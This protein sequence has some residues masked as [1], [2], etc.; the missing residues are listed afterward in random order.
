M[1]TFDTFADAPFQIKDE[2][3]TIT[4]A[5]KQGVPA[6]GQGTVTWNIPTDCPQFKDGRTG[7]YCGIVILLS[8]SPLST[9]NIPKDGV[10][11]IADPTADFDLHTGDKI[12]NAL[13]VGAFY[14]GELKGQG[15][16]LTTSLVISNLKPETA[17]YVAGYAVDCQL[18]Y[19][20]EGVR[21]YSDMHN[22][23][24][25]PDTPAVQF[26][27]IGGT[28]SPPLL[29][30]DGTGLIPGMIYQFDVLYGEDY[31]ICK[32]D[33]VYRV[34]INGLNAGTYGDLL[35][36]LN[37]QFALIDNPLQS[38]TSPNAGRLY[39]DPT[40]KKLSQFDG[41]KLVPVSNV[42]V[43]L[44][45]PSV[46]PAN[47]Y[48]HI[49]S[50][51]E[52]Y[53]RTTSP[54]IWSP[55]NVI[56]FGDVNPTNLKCTDFWFD[57]T[58][59]YVW[60]GT[61][62][63]ETN[64]YVDEHDPS[65][66]PEDFCGAYWYDT[67][68][69]PGLYGW[70]DYENTWDPKIAIF[71][72]EPPNDLAQGTYWVDIT[73]DVPTLYQW[74]GSPG[75]FVQLPVVVSN[76]TT[77]PP[78]TVVPTNA[79]WYNPDTEILRQR[80][81][82]TP[83]F[84]EHEVLVWEGNPANVESCELWW[85][86]QTDQLF[87]WDIVNNQWDQ[88]PYFYQQDRDPRLDPIV[89]AGSLWYKPSTKLLTMWD[90]VD[91]IPTDWITHSSDP[92][93]PEE[94]DAWFN[95][96]TKQ[97]NIWQSASLGSW[98]VI[99]P[100]DS[101]NDPT[102]IPNG[103]YWFNT[104][105]NT[106]YTRAGLGWIVTPYTTSSLNA[107]KGDVYFN[108]STNT[109]NTWNGS[110][111]EQS[112]PAIFADMNVR[113]YCA[114]NPMSRQAQMALITAKKGSGMQVKILEPGSNGI[115]GTGYGDRGID[116]I[117]GPHPYS[118]PNEQGYRLTTSDVSEQAFLFGNLMQGATI[119]VQIYGSDGLS[120]YPSYAELGIG[121]DGSPEERRDM[122]DTI[123]HAL[124]YPTVDVELSKQQ[125]SQSINFALE[126]YRK[127]SPGAYKRG[128]FFLD[129]VPRQQKYVLTNKKIGYNKIVNV[130]GAFR[131][132]S[133]FMSSAHGGGVYGQV[134]LQH[135]Y[136][137]GTYD[138]TSFHLVAQYI[139][140]M[141][142]LFATRLTFQWNEANRRLD[143][144]TSFP[145]K[146]RVLL[147][148]TVERTEQELFR[149]RISKTWIR[150]WAIAE[151]KGILG[152]ARS[153]YGSLPGAGGG[154]TLNGS[155]M[156]ASS[157]EEKRELLEEMDNYIASDVEYLGMGSQFVIG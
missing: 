12:S 101:E 55:V 148:T 20:H 21:A 147:D 87:I 75:E 60:N 157:A 56:E 111:W 72:P 69:N 149:D 99:D 23:P 47:T 117:A 38:P 65:C 143:F 30:S 119:P 27:N 84:T 42:L 91:W 105:N 92:S 152:Q 40:N 131:F 64:T 22:G 10:A 4:L 127:R 78:L 6:A 74:S 110:K 28:D 37:K 61:T 73:P 144:Y 121:T 18:R 130:M 43:E 49:P 17:Y 58:Q 129:I 133:A 70:N 59:G 29:P 36:E 97:W 51:R 39:W 112:F 66:P 124:G 145:Y 140:T 9:E 3:Q 8:N 123:R 46:V 153:K 98:N 62:W 116:D 88:A 90:G 120:P 82:S 89:P 122:I 113:K 154:I 34:S 150:K 15:K 54:D 80:I 67:G 135:L 76:T 41:T 24:S 155:E 14:E 53:V 71:W 57:G 107:K 142:D 44:T 102:A 1:G 31:P 52:L 96:K 115:I 128:F 139:E 118:Y 77:Q 132:N 104:T 109:L 156:L 85:D 81:G 103:T 94:G 126:E 100:I 48:W 26:I 63:C 7:A 68:D 134:V 137:M 35:K 151:A 19:H 79:Y 86:S 45:D 13:V 95:P 114:D 141:E 2:G 106:L 16:D 138:L 25:T 125:L 11:Y 5:F 108:T 32:Y 33:K 93:L 146:E 83:N 136:N 50:E